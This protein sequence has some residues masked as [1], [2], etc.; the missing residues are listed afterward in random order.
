M[1]YQQVAGSPWVWAAVAVFFQVIGVFMILAR[2]T[3]LQNYLELAGPVQK[4][5]A[6]F[7]LAQMESAAPYIFH[8]RKVGMNVQLGPNLRAALVAA[9][10]D[11]ARRIFEF[12][13][14]QA[15]RSSRP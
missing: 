14:D 12:V 8:L 11:R 15:A 7:V 3:Q 6:E 9:N 4:D 2:R 10:D 5:V 13:D 1:P